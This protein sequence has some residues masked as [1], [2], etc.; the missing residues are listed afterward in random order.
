M[1]KLQKFNLPGCATR[2]IIIP[3]KSKQIPSNKKLELQLALPIN[4]EHKSSKKE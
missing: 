1:N 4:N 3:R 2:P